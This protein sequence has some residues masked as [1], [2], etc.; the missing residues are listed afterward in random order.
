[1]RT[2]TR[3][4]ARPE[5]GLYELLPD[6]HRQPYEIRDLLRCILD[7]GDL[8]EFQ[9]DYAPEMICGRAHLEGIPIGVITNARGMVVTSD[10]PRMSHHPTPRVP[11]PASSA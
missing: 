4:P 2:I 7:G 3:P 11:R 5:G 9:A 6:D 1:M 8:D 10:T